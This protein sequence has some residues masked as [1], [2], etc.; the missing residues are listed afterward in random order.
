MFRSGELIECRQN[1][2]KK[3]VTARSYRPKGAS[4]AM[5]KRIFLNDAATFPDLDSKTKTPGS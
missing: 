3:I 2:R 4:D 5:A 1:F